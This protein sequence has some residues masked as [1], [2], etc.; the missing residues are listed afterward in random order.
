MKLSTFQALFLFQIAR[1]SAKIY[2]GFAG[3]S[4]EDI[5][6][7]LNEIANQQSRDAVDLTEKEPNGEEQKT[8]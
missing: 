3:Y 5:L 7:I 8:G 6:K 1:E 2:G 4:T